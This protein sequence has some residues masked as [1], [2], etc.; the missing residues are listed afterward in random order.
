MTPTAKNTDFATRADR[1]PADPPE[2]FAVGPVAVLA[3]L[4]FSLV[5]DNVRQREVIAEQ[6]ERYEARIQAS[7]KLAAICVPAPEKLA[8]TDYHVH[9]ERLDITHCRAPGLSM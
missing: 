5:M 4:V 7:D 9:M 8:C 3:V 6:R 2:R 1:V